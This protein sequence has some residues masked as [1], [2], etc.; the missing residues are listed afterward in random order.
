MT[1]DELIRRFELLPHPEGGFYRETYRAQDQF[2]TPQGERNCS[3]AIYFLL[4]AGAQS[5]LH[6]LKSDELWHFYLG[7]P[8]QIVEIHPD[9]RVLKTVLGRDIASGQNLQHIVPAGV[10]FGSFPLTEHGYS[11]VGCTVAP[12][13]DFADF[14]MAVRG[15]LLNEFPHAQEC[16]ERLTVK[17]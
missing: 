12:G 4:P 14:E 13:F 11:F 2:T 8:L 3:T 6:R 17:S 10:W 5:S 15:E 1:S 7:D 16:I 9:G